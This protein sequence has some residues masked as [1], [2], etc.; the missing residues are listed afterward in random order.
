MPS[1]FIIDL[2]YPDQY[3]PSTSSDRVFSLYTNA[4]K[5][6]LQRDGVSCSQYN[7]GCPKS[8]LDII[9]VSNF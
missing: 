4:E 3:R 2:T 6:G 9:S 5:V 7:A 1:F 8:L